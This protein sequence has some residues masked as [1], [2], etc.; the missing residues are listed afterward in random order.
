MINAVH[1]L[2]GITELF[3]AHLSSSISSWASFDNTDLYLL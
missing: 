1:H 3:Q 2:E